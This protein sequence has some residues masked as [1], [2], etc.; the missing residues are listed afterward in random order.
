MREA[1]VELCRVRPMPLA[2]LWLIF[3]EKGHNDIMEAVHEAVKRGQ[4]HWD[5]KRNLAATQVV[6]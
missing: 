5:L 6:K 4:I 1:I 3:E 2:A